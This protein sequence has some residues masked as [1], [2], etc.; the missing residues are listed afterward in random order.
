MCQSE[1]C[2]LDTYSSFTRQM[3]SIFKA[4]SNRVI[5]RTATS[6]ADV[7]STAQTF[8]CLLWSPTRQL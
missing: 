4:Q 2:P 7:N 5:K 8:A 3:Q 1:V 6:P